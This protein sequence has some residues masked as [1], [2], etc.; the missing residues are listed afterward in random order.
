LVTFS[1]TF[2]A[3]STNANDIEEDNEIEE[4]D[5]EDSSEKESDESSDIDEEKESD[6]DEENERENLEKLKE[7]NKQIDS[8]SNKENNHSN[9]KSS[10][11]NNDEK[12]KLDEDNT[13]EK[14]WNNE[15]F[16]NTVKK[17]NIGDKGSHVKDLKKDLTK[18]GFGTFP[19]EPS[20]TYGKITANAVKE[21]QKYAHLSQTGIA[22]SSTREAMEKVLNLPYQ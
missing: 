22:D 7:D 13:K 8:E 18:L 21:F 20:Q 11:K 1:I 16:S 19:K 10:S 14:E 2:K 15:T 17:Y 5:E 6:I 3:S 4:K 9:D 12:N